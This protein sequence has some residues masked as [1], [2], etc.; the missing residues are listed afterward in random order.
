REEIENSGARDLVDVLRLI[1]GFE[2]LA[3][4]GGAISLGSRG[5]NATEGKVLLLVDDQEFNEMFFGI[6][7]FG[8]Q[9]S[10]DQIDRIEVIR[11]PGSA[12][13]GGHAGLAVIKIKTK[14][15]ELNGLQ[16]SFLHGQQDGLNS[17]NYLNITFGNRYDDLGLS[18]SSSIKAGDGTSNRDYVDLYGDSYSLQDRSDYDQIDFNLGL[19]Y[20]AFDLR[21]IIDRYN[22]YN[23]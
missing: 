11:G 9:Y 8:N 1:P 7:Y 12:K 16:T 19:E 2:P 3:D 6:V 13:Y 14:G 20:K 15:P 4:I 10:L 23:K 21:F 22:Y 18:I 5:I 17:R